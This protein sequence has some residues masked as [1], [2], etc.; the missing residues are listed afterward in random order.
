MEA[1]KDKNEV[2]PYPVTLMRQP[3]KD[4]M[5]KYFVKETIK[6]PPS[7][8][9]KIPAEAQNYL[10]DNPRQGMISVPT[11]LC[12]WLFPEARMAK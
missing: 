4:V 10:R 12:R 7:G 1:Y 8:K 6:N 11:K 2:K 3:D 5:I 9:G